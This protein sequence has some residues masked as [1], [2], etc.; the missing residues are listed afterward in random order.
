MKN[1]SKYKSLLHSLVYDIAYLQPARTTST[2]ASPGFGVQALGVV[3]V[4][5][6]KQTHNIISKTSENIS[7]A[8]KLEKKSSIFIPIP[9][10]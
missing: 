3:L 4:R 1:Q 8:E 9:S 5:Y 6:N 2:M 7:Q 10:V